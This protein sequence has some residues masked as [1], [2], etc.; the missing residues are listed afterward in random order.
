MTAPQKDPETVARRRFAL[1]A[2]IRLS[3][4]AIAVFGLML[5][6]EKLVLAGPPTDRYVGALLVALGVFDVTIFPA[7]IARRWKTRSTS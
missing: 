3:G 6:G 1:L 7:L 2:T 5:L 4:A